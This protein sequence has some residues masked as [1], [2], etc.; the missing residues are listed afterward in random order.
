MVMYNVNEA[1]FDKVTKEGFWI[2]DFATDHC[3]PCKMLDMVMEQIIF[4]NP[5]INL[6][7]C[8]IEKS[9]AYVDRFNIEGTPTLL[10]INDGEIIDRMTGSHGREELEEIIKKCMYGE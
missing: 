10:F 8:D 9:P 2:A 1:E 3:G 4:D 6:A 5:L 7:K